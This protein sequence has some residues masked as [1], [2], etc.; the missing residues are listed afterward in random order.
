MGVLIIGDVG[1]D[2][3]YHGQA[4]ELSPEGPYP[5]IKVQT[6]NENLSC[7]GNIVNS[8]TEFFDK[9]FFITCLKTSEAE[10]IKERLDQNVIHINIS[11]DDR[12]LQ[13]INRVHVGNYVVSRFDEQNI[14]PIN[15]NSVTKFISTVEQIMKDVEVLIL[16]DYG[17]GLLT[18]SLCDQVIRLSNVKDIPVFVD[19]FLD[20]WEKFKNVTLIKPNRVEASSFLGKSITTDLFIGFTKSLLKMFGITYVLCTCLLYTSPSPRDLST[21]RMP[22]S[23]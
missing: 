7:A 5:V 2:R 17:L 4:T 6:A 19:P 15:D 22:S 18:P 11:Q 14:V 23:A 10:R 16:S 9:I 1:I 20:G 12:T 3:N 13:V 8:V 21:S